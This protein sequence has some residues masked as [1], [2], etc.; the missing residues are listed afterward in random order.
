MNPESMI[1]NFNL[2][3]LDIRVF[4]LYINQYRSGDF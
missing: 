2:W 3:L 1:L 4:I